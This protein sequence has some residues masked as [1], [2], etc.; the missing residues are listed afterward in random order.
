MFLNLYNIDDY[1]SNSHPPLIGF[2]Y[3]G[4]ALYGK[5]ENDFS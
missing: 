5:Y 1:S 3:D 4:I 2:G